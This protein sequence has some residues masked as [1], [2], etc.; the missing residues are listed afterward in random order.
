L[1]RA[2][3]DTHMGELICS[4]CSP[5]SKLSLDKNSL[6]FLHKLENIHLDDIHSGMNNTAEIF[7]AISFL[8]IFTCIHLEGMNKVRSLDM[9][10]KLL[11]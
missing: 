5:K 2:T 3:I 7:N 8:E 4:D 1:E 11:K 9:V 6:V 10:Q